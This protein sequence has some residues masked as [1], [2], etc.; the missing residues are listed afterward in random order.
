[1]RFDFEIRKK[2]RFFSRRMAVCDTGCQSGSWA[3]THLLFFFY[4]WKFIIDQFHHFSHKCRQVTQASEFRAMRGI[5]DSYVE[6]QHAVQ[7]A[8]GL[9]IQSTARPKAMLLSQLLQHDTFVKKANKAGVP[10][11]KRLWPDAASYPPQALCL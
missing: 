8:L 3:Y 6:Q 1:M 5:N 10:K 7:R 9:T 2:R 11:E 4:L